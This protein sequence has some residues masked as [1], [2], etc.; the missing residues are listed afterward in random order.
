MADRK[1]QPWPDELAPLVAE[2]WQRARTR[3]SCFLLLS[4]PVHDAEQQGVAQIHLGT[5][6][7]A[8]NGR[9]ILDRGLADCIEALLAHEIG[10]HVRYPGSLAVDA[11]LQLLEKS[12]IPIEG[13]SLLNL[14]TDLLINERLGAW[15]RDPFVRVYQAFPPQDGCDRDPAFLFYQAVYEELW[16]LEPGS[17]LGGAGPRFGRSYHN[18]RADAQLLAQNLF[19]LGPNLYTQFLYFA[20]VLSRYLRPPRA[21]EPVSIDPY[22]CGRGEPSPEDWADAL[23][24]SLREVEAVERAL[25]EGWITKKQ[26][27][28]LTGPDALARR[29][30][31]LPGQGTGNAEKVPDVMA[32]YYRQQAERYLLRPP[33]QRTVGAA[34]V[35]TTLEEWEPGD[36][37]R[38]IDWLATLVQRGDVLG[39]VQPLRRTRVAEYEGHDVPLWQ[40]R[41]EIYLDVSGSMPDPRT[42]RNAMTLA[43]QVLTAG[44]VRAGGWVRALLY[45]TSHVAY[46]EWCRSEVELSRFLMHYVGGGTAF[47]FAVLRES[48]EEC[49]ARQPIRVV[50][51][52]TDF[53]RNY[54]ADPAHARLVAE[55]ARRSPHLVLL[56][57]R[58][59]APYTARYRAAGASVVA[60]QEMEDFPRMAA[61]L[62]RALF[63]EGRHE[64]N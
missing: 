17:L 9:E 2:G 15:Y 54:D 61:D 7:V 37:V 23:T 1:P 46:W 8:L 42:T 38:D 28:R 11:R 64:R 41:V 5:R 45:S 3:W 31:G 56:Q 16:R 58:P 12:L 43:A 27:E 48:L 13:Y 53:D 39:G 19:P 10:H 60:V 24:P 30:L 52:D 40:P 36:P 55:A 6:Q 50:I 57:H 4:D 21:R 34:V 44:A 14:F 33:P 25:R 32:A 26:G 20:S 18:Y 62:S 35:P 51:S 47:P 22:S 63:A 49:G 29:I 59:A